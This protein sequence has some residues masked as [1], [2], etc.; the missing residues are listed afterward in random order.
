MSRLHFSR[1][2]SEILLGD[3]LVVTYVDLEVMM[4]VFVAL[5]A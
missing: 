5:V 4:L 1:S 2:V 3:L